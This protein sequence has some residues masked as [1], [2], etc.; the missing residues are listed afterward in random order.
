MPSITAIARAYRELPALQVMNQ[1]NHSTHAAAFAGADGAIQAVREDVGRHN[2][3]DK[4]LGHLM[5]KHF[6]LRSG[7][8]IVSS[9]CS[10]ELV[11]KAAMAG[12]PFLASVSAPTAL[13]VRLANA[14]GMGLAASSPDGIML[15]GSMTNT[16]PS[17]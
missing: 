4:L 2:A 13:A 16:G 17:T 12:V 11:Q 7:F 14:A 8:V 3:L 1:K 9:R 5:F 10:M 6:D 15:F